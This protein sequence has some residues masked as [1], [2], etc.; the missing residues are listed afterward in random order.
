MKHGLLYPLLQIRCSEPQNIGTIHVWALA[1]VYVTDRQP[2]Q[3]SEVFMLCPVDARQHL[4]CT[5]IFFVGGW[6]NFSGES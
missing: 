5:L 1:K 3:S 4:I 6:D 2:F